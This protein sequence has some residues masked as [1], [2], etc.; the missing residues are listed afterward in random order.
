MSIRRGL[1]LV[2][3]LVVI[4]VIA[5]LIALL[6]P[7]VQKARSAAPRT[8]TQNNMKQCALAVHSYHDANG[9]LPDGFHVGG[10]HKEKPVSMWVH[11]LPFIGEK[12]VYSSGQ[13]D[14][15]VPAFLAPLDPS[16][17][18]PAG[19]VNFAANLR[20][21]AYDT[22]TPTTADLVS[23]AIDVPAGVLSSNLTFWRILDGTSNV[24]MLSTRYANCAGQATWY[25][26]DAVGATDFGALPARGIGGF[27]GAG[28]YAEPPTSTKQPLTAV[29]QIAPEINDCVPQDAIFGH[30]FDRRGM[31]VALCDASVWELLNGNSAFAICAG[32]VPK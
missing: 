21:F 24:L 10:I 17:A 30:T 32:H 11:L 27:M 15:V 4:A 2:E 9:R 8:Q 13:I 5:V 18:N 31:F 22:L 25:A 3:L 16:S 29:F 1:T 14:A 26:T 7:A 20:V 28:A 12:G 6:F 23:T 19:I